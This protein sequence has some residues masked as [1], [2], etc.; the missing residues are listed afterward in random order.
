MPVAGEED[1]PLNFATSDIK[2]FVDPAMLEEI[3]S[4][5]GSRL[6]RTE[7]RMNTQR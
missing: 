5:P 7:S 1:V 3:M 2:D 4:R 6:P